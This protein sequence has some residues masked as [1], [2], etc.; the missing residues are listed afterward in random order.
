MFRW[1]F[2]KKCEHDYHIMKT[3][4]DSYYDD[5]FARKWR[6]YILYCPKC[7]KEKRVDAD[8]YDLK[9]EKVKLRQGYRQYK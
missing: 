5:G 1:L 9:L 2:G 3:I 8:E 4:Y 6:R 7:D